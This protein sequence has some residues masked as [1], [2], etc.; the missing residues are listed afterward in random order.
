VISPARPGPL[1][2]L[3]LALLVL[4]AHAPPAEGHSGNPNFRSDLRA[5][6]PA[7]R[8]L[9]VEV[10]N[11]D[12][13]LLLVNRSGKTVEV[14]GYDGEPYIRVRAN[15]LVEVNKRSPSHY[16]NED[17][18]ASV[19]VPKEAAA[20]ATPRWEVVGKNG[21]YEWHDHRIHY[22]SKDT[23]PQVKDENKEAKVFDWRVP[24]VVGSQRA[25]LVGTLRWEPDES[26]LPSVAVVAFGGLAVAS[27]VLILVSRRIRRRTGSRRKGEAWA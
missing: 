1:L 21:R 27:L 6:E 4:A 13:R 25:R 17:R 10:L 11:Y 26:G 18:F 9:K 7:V 16:L 19:E 22:M 24:L 14:R 20:R 3:A 8:G 23:P 15:G 2:V 12:D 5:I